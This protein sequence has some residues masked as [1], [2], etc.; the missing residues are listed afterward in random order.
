[1]IE[2]TERTP[3][4]KRAYADGVMSAI[5][6]LHA[7]F[8]NCMHQDAALI[9]RDMEAAFQ[10]ARLFA[11]P[12]DEPTAPPQIIDEAALDSILSDPEA[13]RELQRPDGIILI[14]DGEPTPSAETLNKARGII[15]ERRIDLPPAHSMQSLSGACPV[16]WITREEARER[17]PMPDEDGS[18]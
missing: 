9:V 17:W 15:I 12:L 14:K 16:Q 8:R 13:V 2:I 1:M 10:R 18:E 4:E 11:S 7:N 5:N 6:I 3:A